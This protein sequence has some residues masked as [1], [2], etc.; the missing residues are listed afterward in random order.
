[1]EGLSAMGLFARL[2]ASQPEKHDMRALWQGVIAIAREPDWYR[3]GGIADSLTGRFDAISLVLALVLIRLEGDPAHRAPTARLTEL[4]I[5]DIDGQLRQE[6]VGDVVM[7]KRM[8]KLMSALG[9]RI[10]AYRA[11]LA[12]EGNE[13]LAE[14]LRRNVSLGEN[15]DAAVLAGQVRALAAQLGEASDEQILA[16]RIT[17]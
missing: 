2:F 14:A 5:A 11:A 9:G 17:R 10:D 7:G 13:A 6:G 3:R 1:M 15:G 8:G 12:V 4:F 16:G